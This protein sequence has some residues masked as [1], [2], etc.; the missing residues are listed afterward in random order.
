MFH[1][2]S[3]I[4][5]LLFSS[6]TGVVDSF[7][8]RFQVAAD[9]AVDIIKNYSYVKPG[10]FDVWFQTLE[11]SPTKG[12]LI[13]YILPRLDGIARVITSGQCPFHVI[14]P[15]LWIVYV[16]NMRFDA[17]KVFKELANSKVLS[18][19]RIIVFYDP[20]PHHAA[21]V[22]I[23]L[24]V[25]AGFLNVVFIKMRPYRTMFYFSLISRMY[26]K[27]GL[28][29]LDELFYDQSKYLFGHKFLISYRVGSGTKNEMSVSASA[30][31]QWVSNMLKSANG[32]YRLDRIDCDYTR[33]G[34]DECFDRLR[35]SDRSE[36]YDISLEPVYL[37]QLR[38]LFWYHTSSIPH[39][40]MVV[41]PR[42][43]KLEVMEVFSAPFSAGV[44]I[45][46]GVLLLGS[47]LIMWAFPKVFRNDLVL[48]P[49][50]GFGE[51]DLN[52][53]RS[54]EKLAVSGLVVFYFFL[55]SAYETKIVAL[56][57]SYPHVHDPQNVNDMIERGIRIRL[58]LNVTYPPIT[59]DNEL[60][61]VIDHVP[62][63][64]HR[65]NI[66]FDGTHAYF[67][68]EVDLRIMMAYPT[69]YD[70]DAGQARYVELKNYQFGNAI[71]FILT[72]QR[73]IVEKRFIHTERTCA[74]TG[75]LQYWERQAFRKT[76]GVNYGIRVSMV[77]EDKNKNLDFAEMAPAWL[78]LA[79]GWCF[80]VT[81]FLG[82]VLQSL[83]RQKVKL[84]M[85]NKFAFLI[86]RK[87]RRQM[88]RYN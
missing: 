24:F 60:L 1:V 70:F 75:L 32:T 84:F 76:L 59:E 78:I 55:L 88:V 42:G 83:D 50:C 77:Q 30:T 19:T 13:D 8:N 15:T 86:N 58:D 12:T 51:A 20:M 16:H 33:H 26:T 63:Y 34:Y 5:L 79:A 49:L 43:R 21:N 53:T 54:V 25:H 74:E 41:T 57:T 11:G 37:K 62:G 10:V 35:V 80:S 23:N 69:N 27:N 14:K 82:E 64:S 36:Q 87:R 67:G 18:Y 40:M 56:M 17:M 65:K 6:L 29:P 22:V 3:T 7:E 73:S 61:P 46:F 85:R 52:Q 66:T 45:A 47:L 72:K 4:C 2:P 81:I 28:Y 38:E 44:W 9:Y 71:I 39:R 48:L 68:N 31:W